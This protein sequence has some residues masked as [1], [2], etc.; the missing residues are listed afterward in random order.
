[1]AHEVLLFLNALKILLSDLK[2]PVFL[3]EKKKLG[4]SIRKRYSSSYQGLP[5]SN[6]NVSGTG[7]LGIVKGERS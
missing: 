6:S 1:M 2:S 3:E 5:D 7:R 4:K